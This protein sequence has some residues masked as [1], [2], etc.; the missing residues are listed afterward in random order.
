KGTS[1][2]ISR[3]SAISDVESV[4]HRMTEEQFRALIAAGRG[5]ESLE[6]KPGGTRDDASRSSK[7]RSEEVRQVITPRCCAPCRSGR[8]ASSSRRIF[9]AWRSVP[10]TR[11]STS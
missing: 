4:D 11:C 7:D 1:E 5:S 2:K 9:L 6:A 8:S 3:D 10:G